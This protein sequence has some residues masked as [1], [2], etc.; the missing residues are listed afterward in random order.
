MATHVQSNKAS[1]GGATSRTCAYS[2][3]VTS[4]NLLIAAGA[5]YNLSANLSLSINDGGSFTYAIQNYDGYSGTIIIG[6]K[7]AVA[8]TT[9]TVTLNASSSSALDLVVL[10]YA[11]E[12]GYYWATVSKDTSAN[13]NGTT[14][15]TITSGA[16]TPTAAR[17]LLVALG[18]DA[19]AANTLVA[20]TDGQGHSMTR[21]QLTA[22]TDG[23]AL[24]VSD[25]T[26]TAAAAFNCTFTGVT[27][28]H[29]WIGAFVAWAEAA[30]ASGA[31]PFARYQT[32][33]QAVNRAA[34]Y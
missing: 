9:P 20:G 6:A 26:V 11:P 21:R 1:T 31:L 24:A 27:N 14:G 33:T 2:G 30:S 29:T 10:E 8:S 17:C 4:G 5:G 18:Y 25:V 23:E 16:A 3:G 15:T 19:T 34:T 22:N 7:M 12:T 28:G 32:L 13:N